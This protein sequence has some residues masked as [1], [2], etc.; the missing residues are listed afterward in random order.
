MM[1]LLT[2]NV[3]PRPRR[4]GWHGGPT[5]VGALQ[6]V[7]AEEAS[8]RPAP[9]RHTIWELALHIAY[10]NYAVRRRIEG[11]DAPRFPR[12]PANFP[13]QPDPPDERAWDADRRLIE[14]EHQRLVQVIAA[15]PT[16]RL[17]RRPAGARKWTLG[18]MI[19]GIAQ[20]DAYHTGQIQI[21]KRLWRERSRLGS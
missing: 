5:P 7:S 16:S 17:G 10:W 18:E 14:E 9:G 11:G 3:Q 15:V 6:N 13:R 19:L 4:G 12:S 20:H 1:R 21:M 8:W 2:E